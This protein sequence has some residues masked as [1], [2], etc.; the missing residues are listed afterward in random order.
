MNIIQKLLKITMKNQAD[1]INFIIE[2]YK[3]DSYL[4]IGVY[5]P[6]NNF[7]KIKV[8]LKHSVDNNRD[9]YGLYTHWM[10][11]DY[12]F[13]NYV[14]DQKY[15]VIFVDGM[16]TAKQSYKDVINSINCLNDNGFIIMHDCNPE[17]EEHTISYNEFKIN[18]EKWGNV[19]KGDWNGDVYKAFIQLKNELKDWSCFCINS[20]VYCGILTERNI[21]KNIQAENIDTK[22]ITWEIFNKNRKELLQIIS[23]E[24]FEEILK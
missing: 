12:F 16:H 23:A 3:F 1:L 5:I 24:E 21:L 8:A 10:D 13:E 14:K 17:L 22:N 20:P 15:D 9:G 19:Y 11:S 6:A 7:D 2:K 18:S 4:E